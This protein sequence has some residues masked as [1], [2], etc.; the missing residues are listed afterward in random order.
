VTSILS[1]HQKHAIH[2]ELI[3]MNVTIAERAK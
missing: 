3:K 1:L 2:F